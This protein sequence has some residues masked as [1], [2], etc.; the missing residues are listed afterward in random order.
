MTTT[1]ADFFARDYLDA[2][3]K[4]LA[5]AKAA[6][7][8]V[9]TALHPAAKGPGGH[10]LAMDRATL[11]PADAPHVLVI[12]SGTHGP[13]GYC[14]SGVQTG[15]LA[16]GRAGDWARAGVK[17]VMI[18]AH[19]PYGFAWD[20]RFNEDNIDLNRNYLADW[21]PPL[22]RNPGYEALAEWAAPVDRSEAA[23][24][25][26]DRALLAWAATNGFPAL[27]SALS[28]GQYS[29]PKGVYYG[30]ARPSW[31]HETLMG[32]LDAEARG[33]TRLVTIDLH[34]GLGP[35]GHG[36]I[37]TETAP[38]SA[39]HDR[40]EALWPGQV[41]ST[42]DGSSVSADLFGTMDGAIARRFAAA[43]PACIAIEFG[44]VDTMSVFRATQASSWLHC[45]GDREGP[46]A[47]PIRQASRDAFNPDTDAWKTMVWDRSLE[48]I[49]AAANALS[50]GG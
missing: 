27:Q 40:L 45:H 25:E 16:T 4:F 30:G 21:T 35:F 11:G 20:T 6:G 31:S 22:P 37:I 46:D 36:E 15:L 18:H 49:G 7:A 12:V 9:S 13:E 38:G 14:G 17:I 5:A 32:F 39:H 1:P 41:R 2:R 24:E 44:T 34:T 33:A 3:A 50:L 19:N 42:K 26:A 47:G 8:R 28:G 43:L 23:R 10:D 48:V 29:H